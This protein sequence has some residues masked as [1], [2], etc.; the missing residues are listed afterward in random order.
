MLAVGGHGFSGITQA[1]RDVISA[2][3]LA[4]VLDRVGR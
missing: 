4:W 3:S 2:A 1:E